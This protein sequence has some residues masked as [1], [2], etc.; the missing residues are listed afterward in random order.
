[1]TNKGRNIKG[2]NF[3]WG[4]FLGTEAGNRFAISLCLG[5]AQY[6]VCSISFNR[7]LVDLGGRGPKNQ[8]S[9]TDLDLL[10]LFNSFNVIMFSH[11]FIYS[12][13]FVSLPLTML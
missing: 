2:M 8:V 4:P 6:I 10:I 7:N 1:M 9:V 5:P 12:F 11:I 13:I 3:W